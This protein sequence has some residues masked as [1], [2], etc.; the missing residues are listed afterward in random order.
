VVLAFSASARARA[1]SAPTSLKFKLR[2]G[3]ERVRYHGGVGLCMHGPLTSLLV[4]ANPSTNLLYNPHAKNL[5]KSKYK[6][7]SYSGAY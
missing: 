7:M 4:L 5:L 1:P 3:E 6:N 2:L